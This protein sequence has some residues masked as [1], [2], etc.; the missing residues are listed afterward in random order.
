[1]SVRERVLHVNGVRLWTAAQGSG[2]PL[3]LLHGGPG[4]WDHFDE[5]AA[6]LDGAARVHRYDQRGGGRSGRTPPYDV[7]T[8]VADLEAL[9]DHWGHERWGLVG[10]SWGV[11]LALA[12]AA[13][14]RARVSSLILLGATGVIDD[15]HDEYLRNAEARRTPDERTR[16]AEL[17]AMVEDGADLSEEQNREYCALTWM[18]DYADRAQA[19]QLAERLYRPGGPNYE[20]N[21]AL[22]ADWQRL[23]AE[24][25]FRAAVSQIGCPALIMH[26]AEDP[27]PVRLA[28][29]LASSLRNARLEIVEQAGHLPWIE[30]PERARAILLGFLASH[31]RAAAASAV[32]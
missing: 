30:Q 26:G 24:P 1:M 19:R 3:V 11:S 28:E 15:W 10:H 6:M 20:A 27:R 4:L 8:F 23:A 13:R 25:W 18:A 17:R 16:R 7:E 31:A 12:Y 2:A 14:H 5:L 29:R 21:A 22:N 9:R 32:P